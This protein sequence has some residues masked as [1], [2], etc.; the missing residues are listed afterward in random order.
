MRHTQTE[1]GRSRTLRVERVTSGSLVP[2]L[3]RKCRRVAG[4]SLHGLAARLPATAEQGAR[5]RESTEQAPMLSS[6]DA[7]RA[8]RHQGTRPIRAVN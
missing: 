8:S 6:L 4:T 7:P 2:G 5:P 1:V 3:G